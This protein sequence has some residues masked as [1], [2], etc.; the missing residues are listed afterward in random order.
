MQ[1]LFTSNVFALFMPKEV[2]A[3]EIE[4]VQGITGCSAERARRAL[5]QHSSVEFAINHI[6]D[7]P[8]PAKVQKISHSPNAPSSSP[9]R[10][11]ISS[12][13]NTPSNQGTM[14]R[15]AP[16]HN[17]D[18][19]S[20]SHPCFQVQFSPSPAPQGTFAAI[21]SNKPQTTSSSNNQGTDM[22]EEEQ[23]RLALAASLESAPHPP[24]SDMVASASDQ[25]I[26]IACCSAFRYCLSTE[27][28][29]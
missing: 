13:A 17:C 6:F 8:E 23:L 28:F 5:E 10:G 22:S 19:V 9:A 25:V 4:Q 12:V 16:N 29:C 18:A 15:S 24:Q 2:S 14:V 11:T 20:F 3:A 21:A 7:D 26:P 1:L 27:F